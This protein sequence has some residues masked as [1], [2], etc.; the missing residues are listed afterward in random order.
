MENASFSTK[1][2]IPSPPRCKA[3]LLIQLTITFFFT[4]ILGWAVEKEP[5][6]FS[7]NRGKAEWSCS[8]NTGMPFFMPE[9]MLQCHKITIIQYSNKSIFPCV[10][11]T[12]VHIVRADCLESGRIDSAQWR[13]R[14]RGR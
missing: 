9:V 12:D 4:S 14:E 6:T 8:M 7:W 1:T 13:C 2:R 10:V 5:N 3:A 11:R